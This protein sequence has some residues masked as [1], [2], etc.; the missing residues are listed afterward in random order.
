MT[1]IHQTALVDPAA[2]LG[3]GV[4]IGPFAIVG[5]EVVLGD[6]CE[7][8]PHAILEGDLR[9]GEGT[10]IGAGAHLGGLPQD[11]GFVPGTPSSVVIGRN[12]VIREYVTI[13]RGTKEGTATVVGDNNYLMVGSH[14]AHNVRLGHH[15]VLA[16]N[17]LLAGYV[18]FSDRIVVGGDVVFHQFMKVGRLAMI[19][20]GTSWSKDI[21][22]FVIGRRVNELGGVNIIGLRRAGLA[23]PVRQEIQR[24]YALVF[25]GPHNVRQALEV[26][27]QQDWSDEA[28]E[29]FTFMETPSK[30]GLCGGGRRAR[31]TEQD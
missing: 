20:G 5:P 12:N 15:C 9:V 16:N 18:E 17:V 27:R 25:R 22:P 6:G 24:A 10:K 21:P 13:H 31:T 14:L 4:R 29:F 3:V 11:F 19:R 8:G 2:Q 7:V 30:L 28:R 26:A 23:A 1:E